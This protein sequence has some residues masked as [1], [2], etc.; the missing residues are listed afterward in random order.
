MWTCPKCNRVFKR[1]KQQHSCRTIPLEQH[2]KNKGYAKSLFNYL[3]KKINRDIG[4]CKVIS[5]PCCI[6]LY[7]KYDFLAILPHRDSLE[8]RFAYKGKIKSP[9]IVQSVN[10]SSK[11]VKT[12]MDI[13]KKEDIDNELIQWLRESYSLK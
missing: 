5:L 9:R 7:G 11:L 6:H 1:T 13:Y 4:N 2:F 10:L 12:C 3:Y 8:I